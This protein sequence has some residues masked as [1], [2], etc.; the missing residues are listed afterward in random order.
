[1]IIYDFNI[2]RAIIRPDKTDSILI[3]DA[4]AVLTAPAAFQ[5]LKPV[6]GR[7]TEEIQRL[8]RIQLGQFTDGCIFESAKLTRSAAFK[9]RLRMFAAKGLNHT[10]IVLRAT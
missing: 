10:N 9:K 8:R 3:V 6:S 2:F 7:R 4:D 5:R 1:M